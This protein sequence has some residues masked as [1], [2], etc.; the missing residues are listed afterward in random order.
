MYNMTPAM[1]L[2][3][4]CIVCGDTPEMA[5]KIAYP[6]KKNQ[7]VRAARL[8]CNPRVVRAIDMLTKGKVTPHARR[9]ELIKLVESKD[10]TAATRLGALKELGALERAE[11]EKPA[12]K[13]TGQ[14]NELLQ[15]KLHILG[16][17]AIAS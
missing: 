12:D 16:K 5:I 11:K 10:V 2:F 15:E 14:Q 17:K 8:L 9:I 13:K 6:D 3:I 1:Q 4:R 7:D